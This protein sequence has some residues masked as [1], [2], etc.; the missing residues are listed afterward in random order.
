MISVCAL[1]LVGAAGMM[2]AGAQGSGKPTLAVLVVG[3]KTD[4]QGAKVDATDL[5]AWGGANGINFVQMVDITGGVFEMGCKSGRDGSCDSDETLH[6]VKVN[7]FSIGKYPVTQAQ[8][9]YVMGELPYIFSY[10]NPDYLGDNKPMIFVSHDDI[11]GTNGFLAKLN[12]LTGKNYRLPTEAEWEYAARGCSAGSCESYTYSGS[13][14]VGDVAQHAVNAP[15]IQLVGTKAPNKLGIY[16]M[17]GNVWEWCSDRYD[18]YYGAG[19][20]SALTSATSTSPIANPTG[21][22]TGSNRVLRG[23]SYADFASDVRVAYRGYEMTGEYYDNFG[24]RLVLP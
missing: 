23:G 24:F 8:W 7:S 22:S 12:A 21:P 3:M 18:Q 14:T 6:W 1:L 20:S 17:T 11:V 19:S 9:K 13:N 16:D 4:A 15:T 10:A 2:T 5:A